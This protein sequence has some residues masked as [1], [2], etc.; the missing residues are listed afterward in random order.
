M[1]PQRCLWSIWLTDCR[2]EAMQSESVR[3][4]SHLPKYQIQPMARA[5]QAD[6]DRRRTHQQ[7]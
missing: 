2:F 7:T 1:H 4:P 6:I 5:T 3:E